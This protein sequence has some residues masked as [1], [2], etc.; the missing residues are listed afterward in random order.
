MIG[1]CILHFCDFLYDKLSSILAD[2]I[3]CQLYK[4]RGLDSFKV[5]GPDMN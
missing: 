5:K 1:F 3:Y 2:K 4:L